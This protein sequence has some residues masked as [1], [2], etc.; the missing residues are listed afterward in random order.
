MTMC[1]AIQC[2][3]LGIWVGI[4]IAIQKK[5]TLMQIS[6]L[7]YIFC[8]QIVVLRTAP[9]SW[10]WI[11]SSYGSLPSCLPSFL[12]CLHSFL[13]CLPSF[14][15]CLSLCLCVFCF[16][17]RGQGQDLVFKI[18]Q[19]FAIDVSCLFCFPDK[20]LILIIVGSVF[21]AIILILL[22]AVSVISV[23]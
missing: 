6:S 13:P 4:K 9:G 18:Y 7:I 22:T 17:V 21:G 2:M 23:R 1:E 19:E 5:R 10:E 12:P 14:L 16:I 8:V 3:G 11:T 15:P 20:E